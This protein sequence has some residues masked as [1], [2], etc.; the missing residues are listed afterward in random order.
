MGEWATCSSSTDF[1]SFEKN[2][3]TADDIK[4]VYLVGSR[5]HS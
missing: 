5:S 2:S 1:L 3:F 4:I